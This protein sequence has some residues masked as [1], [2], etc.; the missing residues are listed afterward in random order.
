MLTTLKT[1]RRHIHY[2]FGA[3][4]SKNILVLM[5]DLGV[6]YLSTSSKGED[7]S[8]VSHPVKAP[9]VEP[10]GSFICPITYGVMKDPVIDKHGHTFEKAA[11]T[12]WLKSHT[13]CPMNQQ[14]ITLEE[15][16]PN[17]ALKDLIDTYPPSASES[18]SPT[19]E[20]RP[21]GQGQNDTIVQQ[22]LTSAQNVEK[23]DKL[24]DAEKLYLMA[25]P[26]ISKSEDYSHLPHLYEKMGQKE[27]AAACYLVLTDLQTAEGKSLEATQS[28]RKSYE[29]VPSPTVKERLAHQ[30][31]ENGDKQEASQLYLELSQQ[32]L[33][34]QA[35]SQ[36]IT[37]CQQALEAFRGWAEPWKTMAGL[38]KEPIPTLLKGA[39]EGS[40]PLKE[41]IALCQMA[42]IKE[43]E[44]MPAQM[45]L[46]N[47]KQQKMKEKIKQLQEIIEFNNLKKPLQPSRVG[48]S[49]VAAIIP[50]MA[51]GKAAWAQYFGD[52]GVEPPLPPNFEEILNS[53]CPFWSGKRLRE[54]HL[55]TLIPQTV[56]EQPFTLNSLNELVQKPKQGSAAKYSSYWEPIQKELGALAPQKSY[57]VL[58]TRDVIPNSRSKKFD[59]QK[60]LIDQNK[61]YA[62]PLLL[63]AAT[64]LLMEQVRTGT[65]LYTD[66][67]YT[68]TR[69]QERVSSHPN[70]PL[71][72][73]GFS[74]AGL[75]VGTDALD[76]ENE[77]CGVGPLRKF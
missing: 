17:R 61:P 69:C 35:Q 72:V 77:Y 9:S 13:T 40:M 68:Y 28:L 15:L 37:L 38:Q 34:N 49:P 43:P 63:E 1:W 11:I 60:G 25:L 8:T 53:P 31:K 42:L 2:H 75:F 32:H 7:M 29:N 59:A 21:S 70:N 46:M 14:P 23:Q 39:Q 47:L 56:N 6:S 41:R 66:S 54:T 67:P 62:M 45:L 5:K 48:T 52:I 19:P 74:S 36:A 30:L 27:K 22:L 64:S 3:Y 4:T 18:P 55:L 26:F 24:P 73:G 71:V 51:F 65:R 20:I 10:H 12:T 57:W 44:H 76:G 50:A 33:Y 16:T 58:M